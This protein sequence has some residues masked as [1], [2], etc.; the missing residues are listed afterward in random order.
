M[1][2]DLFRKKI[3]IVENNKDLHRCLSAFDLVMLGIGCI[4]GTGI[5]VLTGIVAANQ[6]GPGVIFSFLIAGFA[7]AFAALS[8]AEL[9]SSIGG[10]GSAYG[11]SYVAF[12]EFIAWM[13][14]WILLLEYGIAI[15]AV[16]NGWSG[17]FNNALIAVGL[18]LP[19][20]LTRPPAQDGIINLPASLIILMIMGLLILGVKQ[21][22]KFNAA[23]VFLKVAAI[24][25]FILIALFHVNPINWSPFLPYGW[26]DTLPSGKTVGVLAGASIVFFAYIGFDAV[27]TAAEEAINPQ[28]D[29]PIGIIG[30]LIF[31]TLIYISVSAL[32]TGMLPYTN[33]N[34]SSPVA[35][36]LQKI[37]LNSASAI[38]ATGVIAGLTTVMLVLYY[39]LTRIILAMSRDGLLPIKLSNINPRTRTPI[40]LII[41]CGLVMSLI[42][43]FVSLGTLAEIV[44][45][46]TLSAFTVVCFGV[47]ALRNHGKKNSLTFRNKWHP[48]VPLMGISACILLMTF[49]PLATWVRFFSWLLVGILIYFI[50]SYKNSKLN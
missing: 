12:G 9:A 14:G 32:L 19:D 45:I 41:I 34:V 35:F 42:A 4:I 37:G 17:Y 1:F 24:A 18:G 27:S 33:L 40:K 48:L 13:V 30:S 39:A 21:S 22:A 7:C 16:A 8:Y 46:G 2:K 20:F 26:F 43:G 47:I 11:Y 25:I 36:A 50:Y 44:N 38:V 49:L 10:C 23:M 31:C 3:A 15:A 5:F 6:A 29:L 28:R